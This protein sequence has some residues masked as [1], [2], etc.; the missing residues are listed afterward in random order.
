MPTCIDTPYSQYEKY[1]YDFPLATV[2]VYNNKVITPVGISDF[3]I[4]V[5]TDVDGIHDS[6]NV[7][8]NKTIGDT[9]Q[10]FFPWL[11]WFEGKVS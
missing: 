6:I 10:K 2:A 9:V 3:N 7:S 8:D 1:F 4:V 11:G 5:E